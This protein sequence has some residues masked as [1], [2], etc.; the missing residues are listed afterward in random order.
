MEHI[1]IHSVSIKVSTWS[2]EL[3]NELNSLKTTIFLSIYLLLSFLI[4]V[5]AIDTRVDPLTNIL[6]VLA[7]S[8]QV[9]TTSWRPWNPWQNY[10]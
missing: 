7:R 10:Y 2:V 1:L 8:Y 5:L 4:L 9:L 6:A 3:H